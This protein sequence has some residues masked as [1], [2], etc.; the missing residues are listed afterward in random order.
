[1]IS[2]VRTISATDEAIHTYPRRGMAI[3]S[4]NSEI[5]M[6]ASL[7]SLTTNLHISESNSQTCINT[8]LP[9]IPS[10]P[11]SEFY[12]LYPT[13]LQH[14]SSIA[15]ILFLIVRSHA[16]EC[17][18]SSSMILSLAYE[19]VLSI[20]YG[21]RSALTSD[22][23]CLD[24]NLGSIPRLLSTPLSRFQTI[25]D[26]LTN[27]ARATILKNAHIISS[28]P[29]DET[30]T[31]SLLTELLQA[32]FDDHGTPRFPLGRRGL[33]AFTIVNDAQFNRYGRYS[34]DLSLRHT[35]LLKYSL[36]C[37]PSFAPCSSKA[38]TSHRAEKLV[39]RQPDA[40]VMLSEQFIFSSNAGFPWDTIETEPQNHPSSV[41][42][43]YSP[44]DLTFSPRSSYS[45]SSHKRSSDALNAR[46][47]G[48]VGSTLKR[49]SRVDSGK[50]TITADLGDGL[51]GLLYPMESLEGYQRED[52]SLRDGSDV[53]E[54][55]RSDSPEAR[56]PA[57]SMGIRKFRGIS[58]GKKKEK[59]EGLPGIHAAAKKDGLR[60]DV[61]QLSPTL[62]SG[63]TR[64]RRLVLDRV[65][66]TTL[67]LNYMMDLGKDGNP[68]LSNRGPHGEDRF[69]HLQFTC[70][71]GELMMFCEFQK[72]GTVFEDGHVIMGQQHF[73]ESIVVVAGPQ[74]L[75]II[76][77][78]RY[79]DSICLIHEGDYRICFRLLERHAWINLG[80]KYDVFARV[81]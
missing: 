30:S 40:V 39:A 15:G 28:V 58:L 21:T 74:V 42:D 54:L 45:H 56:R 44:P 63:K 62:M 77:D 48:V 8:A 7:Q 9:W 19:I 41:L 2:H 36:F 29:I 35:S 43:S 55:S 61:K 81:L 76:V 33:V 71:D 23:N 14:G 6:D 22:F 27:E 75:D 18:L 73:Q 13:Q 59:V 5:V 49:S 80:T 38:I 32:Y 51:G 57:M 20:Q 46:I 25:K 60:M 70:G 52:Y 3:R 47:S 65:S 10:L 16:K 12:V 4:D 1:M 31:S 34:F 68:L 53:S 72:D 24:T 11:D 50:S 67:P 26:L 66:T 17:M 79:N 37:C 64:P 69:Y 78:G